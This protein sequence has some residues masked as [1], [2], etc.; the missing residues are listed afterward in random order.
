LW[1]AD[2]RFHIAEDLIT[3]LLSLLVAG[4]AV[5]EL[6]HHRIQLAFLD[7]FG[8][9]GNRFAGVW[10]RMGALP[11]RRTRHEPFD[12]GVCREFRCLSF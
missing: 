8:L 11:P 9:D 12:D 2:D 3:T 4:E 5:P 6:R 7:N 10:D 1:R